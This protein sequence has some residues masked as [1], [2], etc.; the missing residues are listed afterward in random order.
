[1][2][3]RKFKFMTPN[4]MKGGGGGVPG[5]WETSGERFDFTSSA[6]PELRGY[7]FQRGYKESFYVDAAERSRGTI[8]F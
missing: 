7:N 4:N 8:E 3:G 6:R 5:S 2:R 1:M